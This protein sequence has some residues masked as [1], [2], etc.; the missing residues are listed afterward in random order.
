MQ[1]PAFDN[2]DDTAAAPRRASRLFFVAPALAFVG[3]VITFIA[4]L[5]YDPSL[6]PS[7]LI[8]KHAP[9]FDLPPLP[10][11]K[12]GLSS[13]D[14]IGQV[15]LVNVFASWCV[16][17]RDEQPLLVALKQQ[18]IVPIDG[19]DY[20]DKPVD[21]DRWLAAMGNPYGRIGSDT[22]GRVAINWGV[23]GVPETFLVG[24]DG[25]IAYKQVGPITP[26][27]LTEKIL[28]LVAELRK[29]L[30]PTAGTGG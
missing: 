29:G 15:S 6:V 11:H 20:E 13:A 10:G 12:Y 18:Q 22:T 25:R 4:G 23:Y 9:S 28:P 21:A 7:P 16:S 8:G 26:Q 5:H 14:L 19:I 3:L 1:A 30:H 27:V 24:P 17:C 2:P